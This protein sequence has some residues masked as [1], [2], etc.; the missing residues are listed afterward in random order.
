MQL[1]LTLPRKCFSKCR[2]IQVNASSCLEEES[3]KTDD[4][5][6]SADLG[7]VASTRGARGRGSGVG[8][9]VGAVRAVG[10]VLGESASEERKGNNRGLH[11]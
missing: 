4:T 6:S 5:S 3:S 2:M 8:G 10:G 9:A 11:F 1:Q 7:N